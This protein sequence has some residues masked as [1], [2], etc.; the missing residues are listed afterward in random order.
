MAGAKL[1]DTVIVSLSIKDEK[2]ELFDQSP[3]DDSEEIVIGE[4]MVLPGIEV[5]LVGMSQGD[6]KS[7]ELNPKMH[8]GEMDDQLVFDMQKKE[9]PKEV[10]LTEGEILEYGFEDGSTAY[11]T[12]SEVKDD[13]VTLDGNHPLAGQTIAVDI[14][15]LEVK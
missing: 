1:G 10:N 13:K 5:S 6:K 15:M 2:G 9:F 4:G 7:V 14:H 8:F 11:F 12:I 3:E